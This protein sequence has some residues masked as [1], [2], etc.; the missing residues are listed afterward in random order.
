M[1]VLKL[2]SVS[3]AYPGCEQALRD[4]T[5]EV[6]AGELVILAGTSGSGKSTLLRVASGLVLE[7]C[8]RIPRPR[9]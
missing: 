4:V 6:A 3:Y 7:R 5:L 8:S 1:T 9:W 2:D